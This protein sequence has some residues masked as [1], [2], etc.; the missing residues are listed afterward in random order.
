MARKNPR[1]KVLW[2]PVGRSSGIG[3]TRVYAEED[4]CGWIAH[5]VRKPAYHHTISNLNHRERGRE[6]D[7]ETAGDGTLRQT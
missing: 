2:E 5:I 3:D 7:L 4:K 1:N 6:A